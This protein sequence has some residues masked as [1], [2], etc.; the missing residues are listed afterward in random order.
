MF[1]LVYTNAGRHDELIKLTSRP[2][3]SN[4]SQRL[5]HLLA[6]LLPSLSFSLLPPRSFALIFHVLDPEIAFPRMFR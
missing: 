3:L 1:A 6:D 4:D 2:F 5:V